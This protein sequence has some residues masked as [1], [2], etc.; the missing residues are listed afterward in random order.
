[1]QATFYE[2]PTASIWGGLTYRFYHKND[3]AVKVQCVPL[4]TLLLAIN[5]TTVDFLSLDLEGSE[6]DVLRT[7]PFDKVNI[8]SVA[9]EVING[10]EGPEPVKELM[11]KN[12]Y[13]LHETVGDLGDLIFINE[14]LFQLKNKKGSQ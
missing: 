7:I 4:Y 2:N 9:V 12:G 10:K 14:E 6:L 1:M 11:S 5:R 8:K 3:H 13:H